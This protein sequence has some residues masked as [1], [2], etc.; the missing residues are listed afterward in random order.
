MDSED[1]HCFG[2]FRT[3]EEITSW[4]LLPTEAKLQIWVMVEARSNG[5]LHL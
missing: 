4:A 5:K 3:L 1:Q 2:C